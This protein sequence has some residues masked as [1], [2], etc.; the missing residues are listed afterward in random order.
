M[1]G[2]FGTRRRGHRAALGASLKKRLARVTAQLEAELAQGS[3]TSLER[4]TFEK[5]EARLR[6]SR[7]DGYDLRRK[8]RIARGIHPVFRTAGGHDVVRLTSRESMA[9]EG[10]RMHHCV[11]GYGYPEAVARGSC[12]ILF[13]A[14]PGGSA[15]CDP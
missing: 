6:K 7:R 1:R 10:S 3:L 12:E 13:L 14:R 5:A 8:A 9:D 2:H 11:G 15:P 4:L